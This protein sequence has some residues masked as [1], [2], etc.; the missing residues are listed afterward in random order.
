MLT[1]NKKILEEAEKKHYAIGAFNIN[2]LEFLQ[3]IIAAAE[4]EISP[5][6]IQTTEGAISYAGVDNLTYLVKTAAKKAK[7][8]VALHLDHGKEI[9]TV[10][11]CIKAGYTSVMVDASHLP[12]KE[13]VALTKRVVKLA[14]SRG[15]SVEAELGRLQGVE[16][17]ISVTAKEA[18]LTNPDDALKFVKQTK[19]DALAVAV[20]T[21]H[22]A[23]KFK[24]KAKLDIDRIREIK[25]LVKI[26]LV[27]H[28]ASGVPKDVLEKAKQYGAILVGAKGVPDVEIRAAIKA[29]INKINIDTDLRLVFTCT[30]R[31]ILTKKPQEFDPRKILGPARDSIEAIVR[32]KMRLFGSSSRA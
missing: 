13:N 11:K 19:V 21:S 17:L 30:V 25:E 23:Y 10:K 32:K 24:A 26:P 12:F 5:V 14:R 1:T 8:P 31:E 20:G 4:K 22:G 16:D 6:I 2:N 9:E 29:G 18:I 28:G 7:V 27:L 15:I 3:A